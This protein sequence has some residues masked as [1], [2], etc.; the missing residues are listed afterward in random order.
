MFSSLIQ[1]VTEVCSIFQHRQDYSRGGACVFRGGGAFGSTEGR[2]VRL[3][4][5][6]AFGSTEGRGVRLPGAGSLVWEVLKFQ[7][8]TAAL[9]TDHTQILIAEELA[10]T[11][12]SGPAVSRARVLRWV[13][14]CHTNPVASVTHAPASQVSDINPSD[15]SLNDHGEEE[16]GLSG[17]STR[18]EEGRSDPEVRAERWEE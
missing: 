12:A 11:L 16:D 14:H 18:L 10:G 9:H 4:W 13:T 3:S 15:R 7:R 8:V 5:G 17:A 1:R 2:G 6:G